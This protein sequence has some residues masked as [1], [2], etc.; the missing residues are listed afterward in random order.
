VARIPV[1]GSESKENR[2]G[3]NSAEK[4]KAITGG[5]KQGVVPEAGGLAIPEKWHTD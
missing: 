2:R 5:M 3:D 4:T 1:Q